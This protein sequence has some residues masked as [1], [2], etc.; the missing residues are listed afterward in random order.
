MYFV[1]SYITVAV[2]LAF[3]SVVFVAAAYWYRLRAAEG[4]L[5]RMMIACGIDT[6]VA[7]NAEEILQLDM[8]EVRT[9]CRHCPVTDLCECWLDGEAIASNS[10]C[11]NAWHFKGATQ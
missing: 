9:R 10:F 5:R 2:Y 8:H 4:R 1:N 3:I 6:L 11:P 7:I